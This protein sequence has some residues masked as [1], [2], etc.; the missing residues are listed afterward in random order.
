MTTE[1]GGFTATCAVTVNPVK[2]TYKFEGFTWADD[3]TTAVANYAGSDGSDSTVDAQV[4]S[5]DTTPATC[6]TAGSRTYIATVDADASLDLA[7]HSDSK[8]EAVAP[9]GHDFGEWTVTKPATVSAEGEKTRTCSR[10]GETE[11][12]KIPVLEPPTTITGEVSPEN[13]VAADAVEKQIL[14]AKSDADPKGSSFGLL[15]AKGVAKSK[16]AVKISWKKVSGA[17]AYVVY[18]NKCGKANHY[19]KIKTVKGTSFTQNKLKKGTYY[20]YIIVAV[21]GNKALATSKTIHVATKGGKV[22]NSKAVTTKAKNGKFTLKKG[23]SFKLGAKAVPQSTK[24]TVKKHRAIAFETSNK[25]IATVSKKGVVKAKAKGTCYVYAYA[26][27]G[28]AKKIKVT[29]K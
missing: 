25:K 7:A 24:L 9:L 10:C 21:S 17:Q 14:G 26:Q 13:P 5:E 15:Q 6:E 23:K 19:K 16:T 18:G 28:V 29:V 20:K 27:N 12:S 11:H 1:D 4:T 22:G 3:N 2:V 8:T